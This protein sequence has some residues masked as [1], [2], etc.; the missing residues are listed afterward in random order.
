LLMTS[1]IDD[2]VTTSAEYFVIGLKSETVSI[3]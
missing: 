1:E 3:V 2:D